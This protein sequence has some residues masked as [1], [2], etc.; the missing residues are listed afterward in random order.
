MRRL[1]LGTLCAFAIAGQ[2]AGAATAESGPVP[3]RYRIN[4]AASELSY[5]VR[6]PLHG[7]HGTSRDVRGTFSLVGEAPWLD[8]PS[9][10]VAPL[11]GFSSRNRNR[12]ANALIALAATRFPD[13]I[14]TL[15][16]VRATAGGAGTPAAW[17]PGGV[18]EADLEIRGVS[19]PIAVTW[20]ASQPDRTTIAIRASFG[21]SLT[22]H[23]VE[24]PA[25]LLMPIDDRVEIACRLVAVRVDPVLH[26]VPQAR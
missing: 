16:T 1:A 8:L 6:H 20:S 26:P 18:A 7:V 14:V 23:R 13:A 2:C 5:D 3:G 10:I 11:A 21:F 25:L 24:R 17:S 9:R 4:P 22:G 12:D 19:R 15:R